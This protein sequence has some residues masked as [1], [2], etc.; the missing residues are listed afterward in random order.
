MGAD[1]MAV[2]KSP[3]FRLVAGASQAIEK[4]LLRATPVRPHHLLRDD[5]GDISACADIWSKRPDHLPARPK[6]KSL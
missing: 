2:Q 5:N 4:Q 1:P 3:G 6:Y